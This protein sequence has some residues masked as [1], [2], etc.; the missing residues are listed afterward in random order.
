VVPALVLVESG[1]P[2]GFLLPGDTVLFAAG[3]LAADASTGVRVGLVVV[4]VTV[5]AVVGE[6]IGYVTG[7]RLG[8]PWL[9]R[10]VA[11]GRVSARHMERADR[12]FARWGWWAVVV[13]R[14]VPWARTFVPLLAGASGMALPRFASANVVGALTWAAALVLVG[15]AAGS[16]PRLR[17][18]AGLVAGSAVAASL[19]GALLVHRKR[20]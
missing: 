7:A 13:A 19:V 14:W 9:D 18:L 16:D 11:A 8:R 12:F 1:I 10:R 3:L 4:L 6:T 5:A 20:R 15:Y 2:L 17:L